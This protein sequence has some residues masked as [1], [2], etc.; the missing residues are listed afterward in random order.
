MPPRPVCPGWR[1]C[2]P[3][4]RRS[5]PY[6]VN[7]LLDLALRT[8]TAAGRQLL[9][10]VGDAGTVAFKTS[11]TDPVS[12]ADEASERLITSMLVDARPDDGMLGE[13]GAIVGCGT[14]GGR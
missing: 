6:P 13:E 1:S 2:S 5:R 10:R 9:D 3:H 12:E 14:A 11:A 7:D 4:R 8:A